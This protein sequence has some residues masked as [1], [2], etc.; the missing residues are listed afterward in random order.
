M[1]GAIRILIV[2]GSLLHFG[3]TSAVIPG[4]SL[5]SEKADLNSSSLGSAQD[6]VSPFPYEFP[7]LGNA[8]EVKAERFPMPRCHGFILEEATLD[9]V[10]AAFNSRQLTSVQLLLCYM[11]RIYQTDPYIK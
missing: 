2:A 6:V 4:A 11:Q 9:Q 1:Y 8:S 7:L 10:Q 3:R 5:G